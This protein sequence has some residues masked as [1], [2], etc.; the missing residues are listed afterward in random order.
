MEKS[1]KVNMTKGKNMELAN[2]PGIYIYIYIYIYTYRE[3]G[4]TYEGDFAQD[5]FDGTGQFTW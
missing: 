2:I 3:D 1:T 4:E 5:N